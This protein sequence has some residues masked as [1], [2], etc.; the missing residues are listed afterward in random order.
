MRDG[1]P[2]IAERLAET[3]GAFSIPQDDHVVGDPDQSP[4]CLDA[5][6]G[7][8]K[9]FPEAEVLFDLPVEGL[10]PPALS[11]QPYHFPFGHRKIVGDQIPNGVSLLA[12][13]QQHRADLGQIDNHLGNP[14]PPF[15]GEPNGNE[16]PTL[17]QASDGSFGSPYSHQAI[18]SDRRNECPSSLP[19]RLQ[20]GSAR[21]PRV[22]QDRQGAAP[23]VFG[24]LRDD[25]DSQLHLAFE[26]PLRASSLGTVSHDSPAEPQSA[27]LDNRRDGALSTDKPIAAVMNPDSFDVLAVPGRGGVVQDQQR[28]RLPDASGDL[29]SHGSLQSSNLAGRSDQELMQTIDVFLS[30][31]HRNFPDRAKLDHP[32]N[33]HHIDR[34]RP[35]LRF[36]QHPQEM[37]KIRRNLSGDTFLHGFLPSYVDSIRDFGR[38]PLL[39]QGQLPSIASK[40]AKLKMMSQARNHTDRKYPTKCQEA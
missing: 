8:H 36:A 17:G 11:I 34:K 6:P 12:D 27:R 33:P 7:T 13:E 35:P 9:Q 32:K 22:H 14:E 5:R 1:R 37:P 24:C 2:K 40:S 30:V 16:S 10:D 28:L 26:R 39:F 23:K 38:K 18:L 25:L 20:D 21:V 3:A 15:L 19:D 31:S 4:V 29:R